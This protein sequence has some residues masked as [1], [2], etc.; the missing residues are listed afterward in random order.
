M[1][2]KEW[3]A[4]EGVA[5]ADVEVDLV[6]G[7]RFRIH[8]ENPEGQSFHAYGVYR[9]IDPPHRISYTWRW[10]EAENDVGET[11]VTV[12]FNETADGTEIVLVHELPTEESRTG[13]EMG[14]QSCLN[15]FQGLWAAG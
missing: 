2:M 5:V 7:G 12:E 13:H 11:L 1:K 10:E 4:P 3:A 15:R 6:V 14:W 8:M 9:H